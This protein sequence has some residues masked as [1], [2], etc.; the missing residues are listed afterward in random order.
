MRLL[1]L[2]LWLFAFS[3]ASFADDDD[4]AVA[5]GTRLSGANEVPVYITNGTGN[6]TVKV[7]EAPASISVRIR[8]DNLRGTAQAAHLHLGNRWENG[9]AIVTICGAAGR[10]C[11]ASG[12]EQTFTFPLT[13]GVITPVLSQG[14]AGNVASL[15][16]A[17]RSGV[18][19]VNVHTNAPGNAPNGEIR[20]QLMRGRDESDD[21]NPGQ[22]NG[23]G[24]DKKKDKDKDKDE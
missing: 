14:F 12:T 10:I 7:T 6:V 13:S 1:C 18:I 24:K 16:Q 20:G 4:A 17:L 22:G 5:M 21:D 2:C 8:Y 15:I 23:N 19:Y 9:A 11:P 3:M